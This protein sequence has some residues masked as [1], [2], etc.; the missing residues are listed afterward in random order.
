[1][2]ISNDSL[3]EFR[4]DFSEAMKKLEEKYDITIYLGRITYY[5]NHFQGT[6][7]VDNGSDPEKIAE[8]RFDEEV[9]DYPETGLR[10][11]MYRQVFVGGNGRKY[12]ALGFRRNAKKY[13]IS[14]IDIRTGERRKATPGFVK[15]VLNEKY[16]DNLAAVP[17]DEDDD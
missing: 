13:P 8:N 5:R 11:G 14:M 17:E 16:M 1:M 7:T 12:A 15:E 6:L 3:K 9:L 4:A 10:P 2:E